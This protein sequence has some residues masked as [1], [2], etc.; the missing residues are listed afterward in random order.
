PMM[1]K[2]EAL[3]DLRVNGAEGPL[4]N[5]FAAGDCAAVPDLASGEGKFCPP[6][7]QHAVRQGKRV[8]DNI[9]RSVQG[10]PMVDYYHKNLGVMATLGMYKGVGRLNVADKE[11]DIRGLPAWAMAR[12]Y[13]V[14]AMPTLGRKAAVIA[15]W[16]TNL[17][18]RRDIIGIP[19]SSTP[20]AAF[21]YAANSGKKK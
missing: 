6:N 2:L 14:Y 4:D 21:E 17:I 20:R 19:Q 3:A 13:H 10:R 12:A 16:A 5:V 15:G 11:L 7:A 9:A 1:G 18:S 8:A